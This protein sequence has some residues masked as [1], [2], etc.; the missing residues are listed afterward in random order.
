MIT[1]SITVSVTRMTG[2]SARRARVVAEPVR[3]P[4]RAGAR[5]AMTLTSLSFD[6]VGIFRMTLKS[7]YTTITRN[8]GD[9]WHMR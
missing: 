9:L 3:R 4:G 7:L 8:G 2:G 5:E 1:P 6:V